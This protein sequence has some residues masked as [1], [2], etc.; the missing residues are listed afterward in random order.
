MT[1]IVVIVIIVIV[2]AAAMLVFASLR[3]RDAER[4]GRRPPD[5]VRP[6]LSTV[7]VVGLGAEPGQPA[8]GQARSSWPPPSSAVRQGGD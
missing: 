4:V 8:T 7:I 3:R 2:L 5:Q 6:A 1:A